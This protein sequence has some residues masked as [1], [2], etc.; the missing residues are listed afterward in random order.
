M[1]HWFA[2]SCLLVL[3]WAMTF[4]SNSVVV[5]LAQTTCGGW[6]VVSSPNP[7]SG[8]NT[9]YGISATSS[10]DAWTVGDYAPPGGGADTLIEHWNGVQW[11]VVPSP[12]SSPNVNYLYGVAEVSSRDVWAAGIHDA[13]TLIEHWDGSQWNVVP[14]PNPDQTD[15]YLYSVS[16]ISSRDVWAVGVRGAYSLIEHWD[17]SQW[18]VVPSPNPDQTDDYLYGISAISSNDVWAVGDG[19]PSGGGVYTLIEHWDGSQ[20]SIISS[21]NPSPDE[22]YLYGVAAISSKEVWAVGKYAS[23]NVGAPTL[24]EKWNGKKWRQVLGPSPGAFANVLYGV[25]AVSNSDAWAVGEYLPTPSTAYTLT[26]HWNGRVWKVIPSPNPGPAH[27]LR[28]VAGVPGTSQAWAAG[29]YTNNNGEQTLV[30]AYC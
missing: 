7:S 10:T 18:N 13:Y 19:I 17:G 9:L 21:P 23:P 24:I 27:L 14:S 4:S 6:H 3:I 12:N 29:F 8:V 1:R 25:A 15:D 16:A 30:E 26:E 11:S 20:W 5:A 28:A 22:N 2:V